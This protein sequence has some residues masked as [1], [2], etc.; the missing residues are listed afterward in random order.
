MK[1]VLAPS[2]YKVM[3]SLVKIKHRKPDYLNEEGL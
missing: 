3:V 1:R 2:Q